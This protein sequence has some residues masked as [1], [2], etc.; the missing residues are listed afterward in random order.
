MGELTV[1]CVLCHALQG[2][3][4]D[5]SGDEDGRGSLVEQEVAVGA[6][7]LGLIPRSEGRERGLPRGVGDAGPEFEVRLGRRAGE[8]HR[9]LNRP[10]RGG[11]LQ[12]AELDGREP[13][14][15]A[16]SRT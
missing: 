7:D 2:R 15:P 10:L 1:G 9:V 4:P 13:G 8:R 11:E 16:V 6:V 3:D 12:S 5:P 14:S